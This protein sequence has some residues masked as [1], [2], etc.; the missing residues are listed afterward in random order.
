MTEL[1][2]F[3]HQILSLVP[4]GPRIL[5]ILLDPHQGTCKL[6]AINVKTNKMKLLF[7]KMSTFSFSSLW[8][9]FVIYNI[10]KITAS[11]DFLPQPRI[12]WMFLQFARIYWDQDAPNRGEILSIC[13][14]QKNP[15][16]SSQFSSASVV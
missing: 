7:K 3:L 9:W 15:N 2:W 5:A 14:P 4:A 10:Y 8:I 6:F 11:I 1:R 13:N 12:F 16:I